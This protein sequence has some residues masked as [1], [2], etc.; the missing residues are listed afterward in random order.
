MYKSTE[1]NSVDTWELRKH[2]WEKDTSNI[3]FLRLTI[4]T[5]ILT[6]NENEIELVS[7]IIFKNFNRKK[8]KIKKR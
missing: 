7:T 3:V 2:K 6:P 8:S 5:E 1:M 4:R